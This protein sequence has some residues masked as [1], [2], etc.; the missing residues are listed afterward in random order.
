M[1]VDFPGL[2]REPLPSGGTRY[3]VRVEGN[4]ARRITLSVT[5]EH[6]DFAEHYYAA[7]RGVKLAKADPIEAERPQSLAWLISLYEDHMSVQVSAN[8]LSPLTY[9]Q[10]AHILKRLK[11]AYGAKPMQMGRVHVV[12]LRD[13]LA[14]TPGAADNTVKTV[15]AMFA[16]AVQ[17][18]I[19]P[20]NP[21]DGVGKINP[22]G[23]GAKP[24]T[25]ADLRRYLSAHPRGTMAHRYLTL[26]TFTACRISDAVWLGSDQVDND[27]GEAWLEWQPVKAGSSFVSIPMLPP[28]AE[29]VDGL[30]G[31]FI[32]RES[33]DPFTS[34]EG[35]RNR[36]QKWVRQ[37]GLADR[38]SHGVRK[39]AATLLSENGATEHQ[40]MAVL[41]HSSPRT[42][43]VYTRSAQRRRLARDGLSG[44]SIDW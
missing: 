13:S 18:G 35:L 23:K 25:T 38:S 43:E 5:P 21:A 10:R 29:A 30:E 33:G 34:P 1:R 14:H 11:N 44:L 17:R 22:G 15:R 41:G 20:E 26:L 32:R 40:I 28:L 36:L 7:R 42:S 39:A 9:K 3:R 16:W 8:M 6:P 24:W 12:N 31:P 2:L 4:K 27:G 19:V 37:A